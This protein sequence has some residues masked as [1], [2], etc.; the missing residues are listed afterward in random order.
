MAG[1]SFS[2]WL[3]AVAITTLV[4]YGGQVVLPMAGVAGVSVFVV[5]LCP[6]SLR[7]G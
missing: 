6:L 2:N 5:C 7:P 4:A 1:G 3:S